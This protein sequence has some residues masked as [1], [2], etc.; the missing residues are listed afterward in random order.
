MN[1]P[2]K[3]SENSSL[4]ALNPDYNNVGKSPQALVTDNLRLVHREAQKFVKRGLLQAWETEEYNDLVGAG[5][6]G[7]TQ[8]ARRFDPQSGNRFSSLAVPWIRGEMLHYLRDRGHGLRVPR[9]WHDYY[10]KGYNLSDKDAAARNGISLE[11]WLEV[12]QACGIWLKPWDTAYDRATDAPELPDTS[13]HL[14]RAQQAIAHWLEQ[15]PAADR[16]LVT[17]VYFDG[18]ARRSAKK[19]LLAILATFPKIY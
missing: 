2:A 4:K 18:Q 16:Q 19:K 11:L 3:C 1:S 6:V 15:L 12:K 14:D 9:I 8:A 13:P 10:T 5:M 17:A 7:L